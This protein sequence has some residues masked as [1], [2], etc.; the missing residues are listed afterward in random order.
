MHNGDPLRRLR[1]SARDFDPLAIGQSFRARLSS[2][3]DDRFL[4]QGKGFANTR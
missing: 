4:A 1:G 2:T 3:A